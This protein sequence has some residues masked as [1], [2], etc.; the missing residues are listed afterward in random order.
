MS[1]QAPDHHDAELALKVYDLRREPVMRESRDAINRDYWPRNEAE[2]V[3]VLKPEHPLNRA[4]RQVST[5]WEMVYG[6]CK[7]GIVNTEFLLDSNGE[8]LLLFARV[9]PY[10]AA[11]RKATSPRS[12]EKAEWVAK[13]SDVGQKLMEIFRAR[14]KAKLGG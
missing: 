2:A 13:S 6:L 10:V 1:K 9:E 12:F 7:H 5:Y 8:G 14:I 3:A 4:Y 11:I